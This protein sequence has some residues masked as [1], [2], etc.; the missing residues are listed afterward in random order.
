M[1]QQL[2]KSQELSEKN[3]PKYKTEYTYVENKSLKQEISEIIVDFSNFYS[4]KRNIKKVKAGLTGLVDD[5]HMHAV[6][7]SKA[8]KK[9][10]GNGLV[11]MLFPNAIKGIEHAK[12]PSKTKR[13]N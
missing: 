10:L 1:N 2:H 13:N 4:D 3:R 6:N 12:K 11:M 5:L 7:I 9:G 8:R